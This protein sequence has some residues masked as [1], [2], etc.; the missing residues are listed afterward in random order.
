ME[1]TVLNLPIN[2]GMS[3]QIYA[4]LDKKIKNRQ[5]DLFNGKVTCTLDPTF[6]RNLT[7][8]GAKKLAAA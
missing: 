6:S 8:N 7:S 3:P 1:T 2:N 5:P 4:F